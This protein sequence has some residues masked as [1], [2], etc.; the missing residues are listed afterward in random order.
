MPVAYRSLMLGCLWLACCAAAVQ[1]AVPTA[2]AASDDD[3]FAT[4]DGNNDGRIDPDEL[5]QALG[6]IF[7][8]MDK[9]GDRIISGDEHPALQT[10][11]G[12]PIE[13]KDVSLPEYMANSSQAFAT[14]DGDGDGFISRAEFERS[15][16]AVDH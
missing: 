5:R 3:R 14:Y 11:D 2:V 1:A 13:P 16:Q 12:K 9:N 8:A 6:K 4:I 7:A 10:T 15:P